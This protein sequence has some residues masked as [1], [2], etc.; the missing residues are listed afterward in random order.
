MKRL[1]FSGLTHIAAAAGGFAL[2][3]YALPILQ[4]PN[5]PSASEVAAL[6]SQVVFSGQF[7]RDL[8]D[9]DLLHWGE[10]VVSIG[11]GVAPCCDMLLYVAARR[12]IL[13]HV[14]VWCGAV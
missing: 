12:S 14:A 11:D 3:I 10:G 9:S 4:A 1:I 13:C 6:Q 8:Q 2:G 7:R 5:A